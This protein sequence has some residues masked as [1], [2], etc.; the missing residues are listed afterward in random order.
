M[1]NAW[2]KLG[3]LVISVALTVTGCGWDQTVSSVDDLE[4]AEPPSAATAVSASSGTVPFEVRFDAADSSAAEGTEIA[5]YDWTFGDGATASGVEVT[6]VY[7]STGT[8][9]AT[10]TV[11]DERGMTDQ[12]S[13]EITVQANQGPEAD[14]AVSPQN[15]F[16]QASITF[17]ASASTDA[18]GLR[19]HAIADYRWVFGDGT[20]SEGQVV[21]HQYADDGDYEVKL[22]VADDGG[23]TSSM[24][25]T[26]SVRNRAP[27]AS[28]QASSKRGS[29]PLTVDFSAADA[30]DPDGSVQKY[31]WEFGDGSG[32]S[33]RSASHTYA[34]SGEFTVRLT[35]T[36][37]DG[38]TDSATLSV[39]VESGQPSDA[40][41]TRHEGS[42]DSVISIDPP[43]EGPFLLAITGNDAGQ[44]FVVTGHDADGNLTTNFVATTDP[45][46]GV[47]LAPSGNT[48]ELEIMAPGAWTVDVLTLDAAESVSVPGQI[49]GSGPSVFRIDG[50]PSTA[51]ISG[52]PDG[53]FFHVKGFSAVGSYTSILV[54][55]NDPFDGEVSVPGETAIVDVDAVG[56]WSFT[57]E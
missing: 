44:Y 4:S 55:A 13:V 32:A 18:A 24:V 15:P 33:G 39:D 17:D 38:A 8:F 57:F 54:D 1:R 26:V 40:G 48:V 2:L 27:Q 11:T 12:E 53:H 22:T 42:G 37:D 46:D 6:H 25:R 3:G 49:S 7:R 31:A 45:Y 23:A 56:D 5:Q 14:F 28:I 52:N 10:L 41:P 43:T 19:G 47:T 21:T 34:A 9:T 30:S 51:H 16:T 50:S 36:D 29:A 35:V 20:Q